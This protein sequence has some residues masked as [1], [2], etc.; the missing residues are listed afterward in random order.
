MH[1]P[2]ELRK[3]LGCGISQADGYFDS[4]L[5]RAAFERS[6]TMARQSTHADGFASST[7]LLDVLNLCLLCAASSSLSLIDFFVA[8]CDRHSVLLFKFF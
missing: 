7:L 6:V 4:L 1:D 2:D 3:R 5:D 8:I